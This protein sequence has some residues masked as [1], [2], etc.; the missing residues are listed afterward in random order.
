MM[1]MRLYSAHSSFSCTVNPWTHPPYP[2]RKSL[3]C[4]P[5]QIAM[6]LLSLGGGVRGCWCSGWRM[7]MSSYC[8]RLQTDT[9]PESW[10]WGNTSPVTPSSSLAR[11]LAIPIRTL[12]HGNS[13]PNCIMCWND[14][15]ITI[16]FQYWLLNCTKISALH[17]EIFFFP[18][19][20]C[21]TSVV[22]LVANSCFHEQEN[23]FSQL[24][25]FI[26]YHVHLSWR[27][28]IHFELAELARPF[29]LW[30]GNPPPRGFFVL[31]M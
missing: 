29:L 19:N 1:L 7:L 13:K 10:G 28:Y 8:W 31:W 22:E 4:W 15:V 24:E 6:R 25:K 9:V 30:P 14:T 12:S 16:P 17:D 27:V 5:L 18:N 23:L 3:N 26:R 20:F 2:L 21:F 11:K